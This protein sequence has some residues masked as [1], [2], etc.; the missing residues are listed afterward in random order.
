MSGYYELKSSADK[1]FFN[2]KAGNHEIILTSQRYASKDSALAGIES[3]RKNSPQDER[4]ERKTAADGSP[5]FTLTATNGQDIGRSEMYT[6]ASARDNGIASVKK[7]AP[8]AALK[9][10]TAAAA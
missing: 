8:D 1:Y 7:N 3:V 2:L 9:D 6:S 4:Y 10:L 5:Y